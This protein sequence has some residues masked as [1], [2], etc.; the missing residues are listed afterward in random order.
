[1]TRPID[2]R[3]DTVTVPPRGM[4]EAMAAAELGDDG[5][6]EDPT[7]NRLEALAAHLLAKDAALLLPSGTMANLVALMAHCPRGARVLVGDLSDILR[8]EA[9]GASVLGGLVYEPIA[10]APSGELALDDLDRA[11]DGEED[12]M[13]APAGLICLES[14]HCLTGGRVLGLEYLQRVQ[15]FAAAH[16]LPVHLDGARIFNAAVALGVP[17]ARIAQHADTVAFCLSKGLAAPVGS[18][19]AGS[20][21]FIARARRLRKLVGGGMRQAGVLAAAGLFALTEMTC[22]LGEDH[23]HA[24]LLARHLAAVPEVAVEGP[25]PETNIVFF[26]LRDGLEVAPLLSLL[27]QEGVLMAE[28]GRGRIRAVTHHGIGAGDV[29]A[30]AEALRRALARLARRGAPARGV[31]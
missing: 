31:A 23:V 25:A 3:S 30:A 15:G 8:W 19:L 2:L 11:V 10:T 17:A 4:R 13:C 5:Y 9:G 24:R 21:G 28:L 7:V 1:M 18:M 22:R 6:G 14:P 12:A 16:R 29:A 20:V 26:R 27:E